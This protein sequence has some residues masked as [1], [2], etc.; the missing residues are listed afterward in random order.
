MK[1]GSMLEAAFAILTAEGHEMTFQELWAKI[2]TELELTPDDESAR[3]GHFYTDLSLSGQFVVLADNTWDLRS[4]HGYDKVH[5][6]VN[7]VY[8]EVEQEGDRDSEDA[9]EDAA[10]DAEVRGGYVPEEGGA[11]E[12][13]EGAAEPRPGESASELLGRQGE[14]Y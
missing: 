5:I 14:D 8:S 1:D 12:G 2:K 7:D 13:E 11:D 6:D 10:Y 9:A 4:R 3:I